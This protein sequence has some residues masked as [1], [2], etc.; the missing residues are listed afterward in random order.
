MG[1]ACIITDDIVDTAGTLCNAAKALKERG[2]KKVCAYI[3]HPVLSGPAVERIRNSELDE[4]VVTDTIPLSEEAAN[5]PKITQ[6]SAAHIFGE[7]IDFLLFWRDYWFSSAFERYRNRENTLP[8]DQNF[9]LALIAP[10]PLYVASAAGDLHSDPRGEYL[11]I[12]SAAEVYR[13]FGAECREFQPDSLPPRDV[14]IGREIGYHVRSGEHDVTPE[15]W[16]FYLDFA[17]RYWNAE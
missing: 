4:L 11:S 8:F 1:I 5:C 6:V 14:S 17:D 10:R 13:L 12:A 2:A 9:L 16:K 15:D 3:T 7:T